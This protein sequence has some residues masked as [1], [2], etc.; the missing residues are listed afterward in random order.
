[1][2]A[3]FLVR[4]TG[5]EPAAFGVGVQ[6]SIQLSYRRTYEI[7]NFDITQLD[8]VYCYSCPAAAPTELQ[9][10]KILSKGIIALLT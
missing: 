10:H 5:I 4:L 2:V 6:Y 3:V 8:R 1:M 7:L 9:T